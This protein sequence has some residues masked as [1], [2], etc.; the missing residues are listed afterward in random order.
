MLAV[1]LAGAAVSAVSAGLLCAIRYQSDGV[2]QGLRL[3]HMPLD[4]PARVLLVGEGNFSFTMLT[5]QR[6]CAWDLTATCYHAEE[7]VVYDGAKA[8]ADLIRAQRP[9]TRLLWSVDAT[10]LQ[11]D[12][13]VG[14]EQYDVILFNFPHID[15]KPKIHLNRALVRGYL[16]SAA[17]LVHPTTGRVLVSLS[18]G[19]GGCP[20]DEPR[21]DANHWQLTA[22][23]GDAHLAIVAVEPF[24]GEALAAAGYSSTGRR[25][26]SAAFRLVDSRIHILMPVAASTL[27]LHSHPHTRPGLHALPGH[28]YHALAARVCVLL[29][30]DM[31]A[32]LHLASAEAVE[33]DNDTPFRLVRGNAMDVTTEG[34]RVRREPLLYDTCTLLPVRYAVR[35]AAAVPL[36]VDA[37][38]L[39]AALAHRLGE[40]LDWGP[41]AARL[42]LC[43]QATDAGA[44]DVVARITDGL[45]DRPRDSFTLAQ[46]V[47][48]SD[49]ACAL[50]VWLDVLAMLWVPRERNDARLFWV[51]DPRAL[52]ALASS[53]LRTG[54]EL[55]PCHAKHVLDVSFWLAP[56]FSETAYLAA[57]VREL[58][59][60]TARHVL[61]NTHV[62]ADGRVAYSFKVSYETAQWNTSRE[63]A[64]AL[65][66]RLCA[67]IRDGGFGAT[68]W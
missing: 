41:Q 39:G 57:V 26:S 9:A 10:A 31:R 8:A 19:Q 18:H 11:A 45:D 62:D 33:C 27:H 66:A 63:A 14:R 36:G 25:G 23:A 42:A 12:A 40:L 53:N 43:A 4:E 15:G 51:T 29:R 54:L 52:A 21:I 30:D 49:G 28:P 65:S 67:L 32:V 58:G 55:F 20:G 16:C 3:M 13:R 6:P 46:V 68:R 60:A 44:C 35:A 56:G 48:A 7:D 38:A 50:T 59:L 34:V 61:F 22:Q 17:A 64:K 24:P 47:C 2:R 37:Q 5:L 1:A